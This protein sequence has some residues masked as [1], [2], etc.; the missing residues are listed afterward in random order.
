MPLQSITRS[1]AASLCKYGAGP[2]IFPSEASSF[3]CLEFEIEELADVAKAEK[4][5]GC[6][7][8]DINCARNVRPQFE[9]RRDRSETRE[10]RQ[11]ALPFGHTVIEGGMPAGQQLLRIR[12]EPHHRYPHDQPC[13]QYELIGAD[14]RSIELDPKPPHR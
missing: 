1:P 13:H 8:T 6:E 2:S 3:C 4:G 11:I 5:K 9:L 12:H 10:K 14:R 7:H